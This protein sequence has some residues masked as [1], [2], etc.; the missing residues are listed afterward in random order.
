MGEELKKCPFCGGEARIE[1]CEIGEREWDIDCLTKQ[2]QCFIPIN[3]FP[4]KT[5]DEAITA[6]NRR[7]K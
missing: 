1:L 2:G 6:W 3:N 4:F 7:V 5:K